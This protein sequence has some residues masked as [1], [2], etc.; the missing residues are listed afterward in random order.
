M[1]NVEKSFHNADADELKTVGFIST[2][3]AITRLVTQGQG[4]RQKRCGHTCKVCGSAD[5]PVV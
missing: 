2:P 1:F 3:V 4:N 5:V